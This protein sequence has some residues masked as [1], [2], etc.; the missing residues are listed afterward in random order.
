MSMGIDEDLDSYGHP[1]AE[2]EEDSRQEVEADHDSFN[3]LLI[4]EPPECTHDWRV[5]PFLVL[6]TNPPKEQLQCAICG[7]ITSRFK[8]PKAPAHSNDV[9]TWAKA[10][11]TK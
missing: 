6:D 8:E 3:E 2:E 5:N 11:P 4:Q 7:N 10:E 9:T 1:D